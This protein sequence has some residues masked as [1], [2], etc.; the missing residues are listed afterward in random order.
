MYEEFAAWHRQKGNSLAT[1]HTY[2]LDLKRAE[3]AIGMPLAEATEGDMWRYASW[4]TDECQLGAAARAKKIYALKSY[5]KFLRVKNVRSDDPTANLSIPKPEKGL[6]KFLTVNEISALK[7]SAKTPLEQAMVAL[8]YATGMRVSELVGLNKAHIRWEE[9]RITVLGKG[10][11]KREVPVSPTA[12]NALKRY[13][14]TRTDDNPAVFV[15]GTGKRISKR[16]VQRYISNAGKRAN[17]TRIPVSCHKLRHSFATH[18]VNN[19]MS[20]DKIKKWMGHESINTTMIYAE[21]LNETE[22][23]LYKEQMPQG[24]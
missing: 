13:L 23:R 7:K 18:F 4:L 16:T 3:M 1:I 20:I 21:L 9:R 24:M 11:K 10:N 19:G 8:F 22:D 15:N 6:P 14:Q 12:L 17:I 5:Y 2:T